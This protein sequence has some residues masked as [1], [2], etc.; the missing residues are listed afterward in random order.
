MNINVNI[1]VSFVELYRTLKN[2]KFSLNN[3]YAS[4]IIPKATL[5]KRGKK[6]L[7]T[8]EKAICFIGSLLGLTRTGDNRIK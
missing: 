5:Q 2:L 4:F 1:F 8:Y 3:I 7:S 6:Y